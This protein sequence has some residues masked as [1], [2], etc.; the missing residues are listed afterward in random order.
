MIDKELSEKDL[1]ALV[2][3]AVALFMALTALFIVLTS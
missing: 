1:L 3:G 2:L